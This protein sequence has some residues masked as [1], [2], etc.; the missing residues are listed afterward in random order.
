MNYRRTLQGLNTVIYNQ[1]CGETQTPAVINNMFPIGCDGPSPQ[2][3][4]D[5][6]RFVNNSATG[7]AYTEGQ[8][9]PFPTTLYD[10]DSNGIVNNTSVIT[11]FGGRN[12]RSYM[13]DYQLTGIPETA[14]IGVAVNGTVDTNSEVYAPTSTTAVSVGGN[15]I[16]T[17]PAGTVYTV[18][19]Q[20]VD[21]TLT[22][23]TP[24]VGSYMDIVRLD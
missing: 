8:Y 3:D 17:V 1:G 11:L 20:V 19:L 14:V 23:G 7:V 4:M 18:S 10:T 5:F 22:L 12:G 9:V 24:T 16:L 2:N 13:L 15:Y 6:A 21:G